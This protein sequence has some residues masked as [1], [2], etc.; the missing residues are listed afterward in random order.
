MEMFILF[1]GIAIGAL[2]VI[3]FNALTKE[4]GNE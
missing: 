4:E 2:I 3:V 1:I